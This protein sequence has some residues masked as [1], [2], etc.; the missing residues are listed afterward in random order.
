[1][2]IS[3]GTST[4]IEDHAPSVVARLGAL[5][6]H[7]VALR[8]ASPTGLGWVNG[9]PVLLLPGNPVSCLCG[10]DFFGGRIVRRLG[11]REAAWPYREEP[12]TLGAKVTSEL[13]RVDYVRVRFDDGVL[14]PITASG[15]S[16]ISSVTAADGFILVPAD[17]EGFPEGAMV[18]MWRFDLP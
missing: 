8:P 1:V 11:G 7:G 2:L 5:P 15:A 6:V 16:M 10:Y 4:G 3:G 13:G 18:Q 17:S 12:A 9:K 14:R